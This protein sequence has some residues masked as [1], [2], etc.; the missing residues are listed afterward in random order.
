[1][2]VQYKCGDSM[3]GGKGSQ[4]TNHERLRT[5]ELGSYVTDLKQ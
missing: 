1:M 4:D 3:K 5:T 2:G